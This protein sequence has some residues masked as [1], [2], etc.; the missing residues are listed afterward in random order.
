MN[1]M[2]NY[3]INFRVNLDTEEVHREFLDEK[4]VKLNEL[5][6]I[7]YNVNAGTLLPQKIN[8]THSLGKNLLFT[9]RKRNM[10]GEITIRGPV[11]IVG[12]NQ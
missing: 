4:G 5:Y 1:K 6:E 12:G 7:F 11:K 10:L 2:D 8:D 3:D 9:L